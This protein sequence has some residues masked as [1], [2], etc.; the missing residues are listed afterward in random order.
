M[1]IAGIL[2]AKSTGAKVERL[3]YVP[4]TGQDEAERSAKLAA[5]Q[6]LELRR[7]LKPLY[8]RRGNLEVE[9]LQGDDAPCR[10][11]Q[12]ELRE[13]EIGMNEATSVPNALS[14]EP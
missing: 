6:R 3:E 9:G 13:I 2:G 5:G 11:T 10:V 4:C 12:V 1:A 8:P 7:P 14:R